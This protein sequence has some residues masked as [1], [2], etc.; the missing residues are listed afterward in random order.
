MAPVLAVV[1]VL[2]VRPHRANTLASLPRRVGDLGVGVAARRVAVRGLRVHARACL[3][4][5]H[6]TAG[7]LAEEITGVNTRCP[8]LHDRGHPWDG[9]MVPDIPLEEGSLVRLLAATAGGV[10]LLDDS[11][12]TDLLR[13]MARPWTDRVTVA[14][15]R[16]GSLPN[17][18]AALVPR[19]PRRLDGNTFRVPRCRRPTVVRVPGPLVRAPGDR[20]E[21]GDG[22]RAGPSPTWP[23]TASPHLTA[24]VAGDHRTAVTTP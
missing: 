8:S 18:C 9:R 15:V 17:A 2:G 5:A 24:G 6:E 3:A 20:G 13:E 11:P 14:S 4:T 16:P 22:H 7:H 1:G 12:Q 10:L 23:A 21:A 19:R